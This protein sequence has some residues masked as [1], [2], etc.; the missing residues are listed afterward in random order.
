MFSTFPFSA[1]FT[2]D[3]LLPAATG[4]SRLLCLRCTVDGTRGAALPARR[5]GA[6]IEYHAQEASRFAGGSMMK[7]VSYGCLINEVIARSALERRAFRGI[8]KLYRIQP[9]RGCV[10]LSFKRRTV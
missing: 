6:Y 10:M 7:M 3:R 1:Q 5:P 2:H 9:W 8:I 4:T